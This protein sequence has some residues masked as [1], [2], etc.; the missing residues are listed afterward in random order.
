MI[1]IRVSFSGHCF[2]ASSSDSSVR[3]QSSSATIN[4]ILCMSVRYLHFTLL[5]QLLKY[6]ES[7][8]LFSSHIW[9]VFLSQSC[10][11]S[12]GQLQRTVHNGTFH[13]SYY[14]YKY[15]CTYTL[16]IVSHLNM[17]KSIMK[18]NLY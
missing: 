7:M 4:P 17:H 18:H 9:L 5:G 8:H 16:N 12:A 1:G 15:S 11:T 2:Y 13:L 14:N 10:E 3:I 6:V